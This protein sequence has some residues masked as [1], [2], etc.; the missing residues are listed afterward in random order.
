MH[1]TAYQNFLDEQIRDFKF[2]SL[3][4]YPEGINLDFSSNDYLGLSG[5]PALKKS[6]EAALD[7]MPVGSTGSRLLSGNHGIFDLLEEQI[8]SDKGQESALYFATGF[9]ANFS[10]LSALIDSGLFKKTPLVFFH[11]RNHSS[12]YQAV[13]HKNI[14][15]IRYNDLKDL[16]AKLEKYRLDEGPKFLV[17]ETVFGMDGEVI[18]ILSI[19]NLAK[20]HNLLVYLDEAHASGI[21]G[22]RGLGLSRTVNWEDIP[23]VILGT[24]SKALGVMGAYIATS[25]TIKNFLI[26]KASGFIYS[27]STSPLIAAACLKAWKLSLEMEGEREKLKILSDH[28]RVSLKEKGYEVLGEGTPIIPLL[29]GREK[30]ALLLKDKLVK[31]GIMT[32]CVRPP[33]VA[34]GQARLRFAVTVNHSFDDIERLVRE[35]Q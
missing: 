11:K 27:T 8:A 35:L 4:Q 34:P 13:F 33:T 6:I 24:F 22:P 14:H 30:D 21:I 7:S 20:Q 28:L 18:D 15:L 26:N 1:I 17:T 5:H 9:Q 12:V 19:K 3:T 25:T 2:R 16:S 23:I 32:S 31:K 10:V 29:I